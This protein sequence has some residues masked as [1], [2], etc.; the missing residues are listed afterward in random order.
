MVGKTF[1]GLTDELL[2]WQTEAL[3][4]REARREGITVFVHPVLVVEIALDG[5]QRSTRYPGGVALRFARVVRY[6][7]DKDAG[8]ADTI[9]EVRALLAG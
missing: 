6:R 3:L 8:E 7:P 1:K 2:R 9:D 4:E 5:V